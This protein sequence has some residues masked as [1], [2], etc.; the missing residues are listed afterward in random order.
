MKPYKVTI[1]TA[2]LFDIKDATDW[3]NKRLPGLGLRFQKA[4][5]Q[6]IDTLKTNADGYSIRYQ[7]VHCMPVRK[8]PF[9]IHFTIDSAN[10][11]VEIFAVKHT[12]RNPEIWEQENRDY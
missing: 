11:A 12:S 9:L 8:F 5:R 4:V 1:G 6:Q 10:R 3:Y 2:A 7:D